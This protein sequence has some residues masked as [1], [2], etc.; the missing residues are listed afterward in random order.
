MI[1]RLRFGVLL[2]LLLSQPALAHKLKLFAQTE[3]DWIRGRVYF[4]GGA[5]ASGAQIL[6][7]DAAGQV[8][9]KLTPD[10]A[11][12]FAY[13]MLTPIDYHLIARTG[14]G[15]MDQ[16]TL[17][18]ATGTDAPP[19]LPANAPHE[20][21]ERIRLRDVLSGIGYIFGL[22]GVVLWWRCRRADRST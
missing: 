3:G 10:A 17:V 22:T 20:V 5:G 9:A 13:Q 7:Q 18:T 12:R 8:L 11:G 4:V 21:L 6:V 2:A 16:W 15:H 1:K 19:P 14:D